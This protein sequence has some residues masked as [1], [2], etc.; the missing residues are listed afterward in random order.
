MAATSREFDRF[1]PS[2]PPEL[3]KLSDLKRPPEETWKP[4]IRP[5][6]NEPEMDR[7]A[8]EIK[9][10]ITSRYMH[11]TPNLQFWLHVAKDLAK[12]YMSRG[13]K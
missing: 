10:E 1:R 8:H 9:D 11:Q 12:K 4:E 7:L 13:P 5:I 2:E 3:P 6:S